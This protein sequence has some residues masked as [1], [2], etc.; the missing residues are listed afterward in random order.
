MIF[1]R[2][3]K[4]NYKII[5]WCCPCVLQ[6][7][8]S[9]SFSEEVSYMWTEVSKHS[10][11]HWNKMIWSFGNLLFNFDGYF[12]ICPYCINDWPLPVFSRHPK[13][14][15]VY[16]CKF[17]DMCDYC[18]KL[19]VVMEKMVYFACLYYFLNLQNVL[20]SQK[21]PLC[22]RS[23]IIMFGLPQFCVIFCRCQHLQCMTKMSLLIGRYV[24]K[25]Q[26]SMQSSCLS[27]G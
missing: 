24:W 11:K 9:V 17:V 2:F 6:E 25:V 21:G 26:L 4:K 27:W 13:S 8:L 15:P 7:E 14:V 5:N 19:P 22:H 1:D 18:N 3:V 12:S 20:S 23:K 16:N 10:N